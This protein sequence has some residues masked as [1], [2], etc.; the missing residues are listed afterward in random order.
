MKPYL[1]EKNGYFHM[2][3]P[4]KDADGKWRKKWETTGYTIKGNKRRAEAMMQERLK[5]LGCAPEQ[6]LANNRVLFLDAMS[7]WLDDVKSTQI[8]ANTLE[9]YKNAFT[10]NIK[11]YVPFKGL[12]L[13]NLTPSILQGFYSAKIKGGLSANSVHK[14]HANINSFLKY[15]V[16]M[17]MIVSNPAER[18][19]LPRKEHSQV[20]TAYTAEQ[21]KR[22]FTVFQDDP[23]NLVVFLAVNFGLRRSE[24]CGLLWSDV[25]FDSRS[26][27]IRHTAIV[28]GGK[29]EYLE[30][31]KSAKSR[32]ILPMSDHVCERL[33]S[34]K[35]EQDN[36]KID[37][38]DSWS[39]SDCVCLRADGKPLDPTFVSH[40]FARVLKKSDLP[41]IRLHDLRHTVASLLHSGG[42]DIK[43]IQSYLGHSD[44]ATTANIYTHLEQSRFDDMVQAIGRDILA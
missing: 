5:Q 28:V 29:V 40:H 21:V 24:I 39:N 13:R 2:V 22:L 3:F 33:K 14:L 6:V 11:S 9:Q 1:I 20:G 15:A 43:D 35:A 41:Y 32:R 4:Y 27:Y 31:T 25:N 34:V 18:V 19:S 7:D 23:L 26:I 17:D 16:C 8:R 10:Y 37:C 44:V 30:R 42:F 12:L 38:G 36:R